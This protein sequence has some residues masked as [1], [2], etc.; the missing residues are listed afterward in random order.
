MTG[1]PSLQETLQLVPYI[2]DFGENTKPVLDDE[3][4]PINA[5]QM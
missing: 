4:A 2:I 5:G 3:E 1:S